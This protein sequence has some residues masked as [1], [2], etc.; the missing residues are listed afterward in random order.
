VRPPLLTAEQLAATLGFS[1]RQVYRLVEEAGLPHYKIGAALRF[2][3]E[4]VEAWLEAKRAGDWPSP[5]TSH[6]IPDKMV[7]GEE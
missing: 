3:P 2:E 1:R 5:L 6:L 7:G 4:A